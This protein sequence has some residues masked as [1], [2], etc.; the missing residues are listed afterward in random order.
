MLP[1]SRGKAK[2]KKTHVGKTFGKPQTK[3]L[4]KPKGP[5][6]TQ[7]NHGKRRKTPIFPQ[8]PGDSRPLKST[9]GLDLRGPG[10]A[11]FPRPSE[12]ENSE[13]EHRSRLQ[14]SLFFLQ[15][16]LLKKRTL[17]RLLFPKKRILMVSKRRT[18]CEK[19]L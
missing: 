5:T 13:A 3:V 4:G 1:K 8:N 15:I 16:F 10:K 18:S 7:E 2:N 12:A 17:A 9:P 14:V 11:C 19:E 6:K